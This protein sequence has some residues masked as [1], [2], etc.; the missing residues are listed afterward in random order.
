MSVRRRQPSPEIEMTRECCARP[1]PSVCLGLL[2]LLRRPL[3][4]QVAGYWF[5][6]KFGPLDSSRHAFPPTTPDC[7]VLPTPV[8]VARRRAGIQFVSI[9]LGTSDDGAWCAVRWG[10]PRTRPVACQVQQPQGH[11]G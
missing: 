8:G 9:S 6:E 10:E 3:H 4:H 11:G 5:T 7:T 1:L 2:F